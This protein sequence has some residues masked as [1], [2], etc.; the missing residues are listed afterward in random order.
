[1]TDEA[2]FTKSA[3]TFDYR[4]SSAVAGIAA[5]HQTGKGKLPKRVIINEKTITKAVTKAYRESFDKSVSEM[6]DTGV[7]TFG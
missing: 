1:M 6:W 5:A 2:I 3:T 4:P 7:R